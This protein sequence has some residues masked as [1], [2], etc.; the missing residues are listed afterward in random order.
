MDSDIK[1]YSI[2]DIVNQV[3]ENSD[4]IPNVQRRFVWNPAQVENIWDS[5]LRGYPIGSFVFNKKSMELLDGQQRATSICMG[6]GK[7]ANLDRRSQNFRLFI[8]LEKTKNTDKRMYIF[9]IITKS[10]PWGYQKTDNTKT[11][12]TNNIRDALEDY[13]IEDF[14]SASIDEFWPYDAALPVLSLIHI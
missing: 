10:H 2:K 8:D 12:T 5:I 3:Q 1:N 6:F 7:V 9:R 11:L 13:G 14:I 4:I